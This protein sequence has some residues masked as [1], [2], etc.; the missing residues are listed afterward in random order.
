VY[1]RSK[2][3]RPIGPELRIQERVR[4]EW[5]EQPDPARVC[6]H[7]ENLDFDSL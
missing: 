2:D 4:E 1:F 5:E 3:S 6:D 7:P